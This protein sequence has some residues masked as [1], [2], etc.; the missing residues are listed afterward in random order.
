MSKQNSSNKISRRSFLKGMGSGILSTATLTTGGLLSKEAAARILG[1]EGEAIRGRTTI[2]LTVNGR[3]HRL[4]VEP[5]TT[6]LSA[7]RDRLNLTGPK[8]GCDRGHCG[9]CTVL[10]DGKAVLAC[11]TLAVDARGKTITTVEG[12]AKGDELSPVQKA[13][14]EKDGLMCGFCTPGL[15]V[16]ATALLQENPNPTLDD[17]KDGLAGNLCRCGTYPKVFEA[18]QTAAKSMRKGG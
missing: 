16:A 8:E 9:A 6:L 5:R 10:M 13:F 14:V 3:A 12:L 15:V 17:I 11:M 2:T 18:V 1:P 7:L 4:A